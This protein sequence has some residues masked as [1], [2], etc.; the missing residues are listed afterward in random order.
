MSL[1][2]APDVSL[3]SL[4]AAAERADRLRHASEQANYRCYVLDDPTIGDGEYDAMLRELTALEA[5]FPELQR[6][7]S[8][9]Q[10]VGAGPAAGFTQRRHPV[11]MLSLANCTSP[12]ELKAWLARVYKVIDEPVQ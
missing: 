6:P 12:E 3:E 5:Q 4:E 1:P 11:P 9:T 7:D 8:P 10:R 2:P